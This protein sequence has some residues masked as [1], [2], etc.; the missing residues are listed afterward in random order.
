M[1]QGTGMR[2]NEIVQ[3]TWDKVDLENGFVRLRASETKTQQGRSVKLLPHV[4]EMLRDIP[5]V[6]HTRRVFLS[7]SQKPLSAWTTYCH[8]VWK[9]TL[10]QAGVEGA[11]FHDLR[12]DFVTKAI[13]SGN[14]PHLVMKQVGHKSD[15]MLRRYH[16][17]DETDLDGLKM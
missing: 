8:E 16:L 7:A 17:I 4:L 15:D 14:P 1:A 12:H 6:S 13:R 2:Q 11:C 3:L 5:R 9:K 10:N